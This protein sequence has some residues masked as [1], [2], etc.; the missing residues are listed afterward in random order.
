MATTIFSY[1]FTDL[2]I[3]ATTIFSYGFNGFTDYGDY[4][5]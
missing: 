2:R 4:D 1:G 5:F 3:M